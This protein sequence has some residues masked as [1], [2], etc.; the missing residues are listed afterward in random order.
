MI[1]FA[2]KWGLN[3]HG[4]YHIVLCCTRLQSEAS[5]RGQSER[6]GI[7]IY[8]V[9]GL[10]APYVCEEKWQAEVGSERGPT[11]PPRTHCAPPPPLLQTH[12]S[13]QPLLY[14][15]RATPSRWGCSVHLNTLGWVC[16]SFCTSMDITHTAAIFISASDKRADGGPAVVNSNEWSCYLK[17]N[18][19]LFDHSDM[20]DKNVWGVFL[21]L[22]LWLHTCSNQFAYKCFHCAAKA[23][24]EK[25]TM[26]CWTIARQ[27]YSC[28]NCLR[29]H[30][31]PFT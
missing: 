24:T 10:M 6:E 20:W 4:L 22:L 19:F 7:Y 2:T 8:L 26:L 16:K 28:M 17:T 5:R 25:Q 13:Y 23:I 30:A 9:C 3:F 31:G 15:C 11:T 27:V 29:E 14:E 1:L 18:S 21:P 12:A